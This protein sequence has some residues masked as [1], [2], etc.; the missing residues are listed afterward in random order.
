MSRSGQGYTGAVLKASRLGLLGIACLAG[1]F[2]SFLLATPRASADDGTGTEPT[3]TTPTETTPT[4]PRLIAPGVTVGNL[5]VGGLTANEARAAIEKRFARSFPLVVTKNWSKRVTPAQLGAR[6]LVGRALESALTAD[7]AQRVR[8]DVVIDDGVLGRF[9][10][11]LGRETYRRPLDARLRLVKLKPVWAESR[12]G[13]QLKEQ[14]A[15]ARLRAVLTS[16]LRDPFPLPFS[17][18]RPEVAEPVTNKVIV[19]LRGSNELRLYA[20]SRLKRV[21]HVATGRSEYPTPL[22]RWE[23]VT[24]QRNPWWYP[25]VGSS[26]AAGK[27]PVPPGPGN[28][29]GT[30]WMGLSAPAVGIHGTPDAASIGYSA[31]HGCIRMLIWQAEWLFDHVDVGTTVFIVAA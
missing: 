15:A 26:W 14:I 16:G 7:V 8:L 28:P 10:A 17:E 30:R 23:I 22:G 11:K 29:L 21:F 2:L 19:I 20:G 6:A 5:D 12:P 27:E 3:D 18:L 24:K 25:P 9:L 31:S 1:V 4:G 13:R